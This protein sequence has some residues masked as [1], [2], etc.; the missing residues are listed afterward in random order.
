ML[1]KV[2]TY[3]LVNHSDYTIK[4][5]NLITINPYSSIT[6]DESTYN[7]LIKLDCFKSLLNHTISCFKY[8]KENL[9][10][11]NTTI[12]EINTTNNIK[13]RKRKSTTKTTKSK[14]VT[15]ETEKQIED[16]VNFEK[17]I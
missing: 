14:S 7:E 3:N 6:I 12:K 13:T 10:F 5:D 9:V 11:D 16:V 17:D 15:T 8:E 4:I 2:I 1:V